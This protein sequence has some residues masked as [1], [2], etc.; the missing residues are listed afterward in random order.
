MD[1]ELKGVLHALQGMEDVKNIVEVH[2]RV[3]VEGNRDNE[4]NYTPEC[5]EFIEAT[6]DGNYEG[7]DGRQ[8]WMLDEDG[9]FM[10]FIPVNAYDK[11][12]ALVFQFSDDEIEAGLI[13]KRLVDQ[14]LDAA[15]YES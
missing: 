3:C 7:E 1:K 4:L 15:G 11:F 10:Y 14:I 8:L 6:S 2:K 9:E 5:G 12:S 13:A